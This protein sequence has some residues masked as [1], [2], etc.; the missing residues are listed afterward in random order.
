YRISTPEHLRGFRT[1]TENILAGATSLDATLDR[2]EIQL[3]DFAADT[4]IVTNAQTNGL[5]KV[6]ET[7]WH[8]KELPHSVV[9]KSAPAEL[10]EKHSAW[11]YEMV[12]KQYQELRRE[13][14]AVQGELSVNDPADRER[15]RHVEQLLSESD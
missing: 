1:T 3:K 13:L 14:A 12:R 11:R 2:V 9:D 4:R 15:A 6:Q 10:A 7:L 5:M 8:F